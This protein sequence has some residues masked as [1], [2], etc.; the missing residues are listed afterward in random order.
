M[1]RRKD[2]PGKGGFWR[3]EPAYADMFVDGVFK[4]R[5]GVITQKTSKKSSSRSK[6]KMAKKAEEIDSKESL[7]KQSCLKRAFST[8]EQ[9][10]GP[11][12]KKSR[13][14]PIK[15][16]TEPPSMYDDEFFDEEIPPFSGGLKGDFS[17]MS[18][19]TNYELDE[20]IKEIADAHGIALGGH[21]H[22]ASPISF[23]MPNCLSPPLSSESANETFQVDP[24]LDLTIQG[25][26]IFPSRQNL[27]TP[28]P[29]TLNDNSQSVYK[30]PPSPSTMYEEDHPWAETGSN[31]M[32]CFEIDE[33]NNVTDDW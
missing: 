28:S 15:V 3:I 8:Q 31:G 13:P 6:E 29:A 20:G 32:P 19:L 12:S 33:D 18:V 25:I 21:S 24:D 30:M 14:A 23:C 9:R 2:E 16:K 10:D 22:T 4:R 26:S 5:R 7:H 1:P 11:R 27:S 17:W